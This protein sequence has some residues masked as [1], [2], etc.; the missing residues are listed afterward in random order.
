MLSGRLVVDKIEIYL[1]CLQDAKKLVLQ[2]FAK[3]APVESSEPKKE[4]VASNPDKK[5]EHNVQTSDA[6]GI[7]AEVKVE[8]VERDRPNS[9]PSVKAPETKFT[10]DATKT[11]E[12]TGIKEQ[13]TTNNAKVEFPSETT[14]TQISQNTEGGQ[15]PDKEQ[16]L[17]PS[18]EN[19]TE[20]GHVVDKV[21]LNVE[22][23]AESAKRTNSF[24]IA[25]ASAQE[26]EATS[27]AQ[28][29]SS[30]AEEG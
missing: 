5:S 23:L 2:L 14:E 28:I 8:T 29:K 26:T 18:E 17:S 3:K 11:S 30:T 16:V 10:E 7:K 24:F 19:V 6:A 4:S 15:V 9:E 21:T 12:E 20:G 27:N 22:P 13:K 25:G 1:L